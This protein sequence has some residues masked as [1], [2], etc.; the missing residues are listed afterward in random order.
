VRVGEIV[1]LGVRLKEPV[2]VPVADFEPVC[3]VVCEG[4]RVREG[5]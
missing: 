5:V 1:W 3:E 4:V 2:F